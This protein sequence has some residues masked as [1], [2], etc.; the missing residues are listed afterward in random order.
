MS[1]PILTYKRC[2]FH[3][4][5]PDSMCQHFVTQHGVGNRI[6]CSGHIEEFELSD[7][8]YETYRIRQR[9]TKTPCLKERR[10][11][12]T[13]DVPRSVAGKNNHLPAET[14]PPLL[15]LKIHTPPIR[16]SGDSLHAAVGSTLKPSASSE[17]S[18]GTA[19]PSI[20]LVLFETLLSPDCR[21]FVLL[22]SHFL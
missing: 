6:S 17:T 19:L 5:Y 12:Q 16:S 2:S 13:A 3:S 15:S 1:Q 7:V 8:E 9:Q 21:R 22:R 10:P 14:A 18:T 11:K 20:V 4:E